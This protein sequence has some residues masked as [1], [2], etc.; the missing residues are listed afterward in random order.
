MGGNRFAALADGVPAAAAP[1]AR[2][3]A[4]DPLDRL[5]FLPVPRAPPASHRGSSR[6]VRQRH[7]AAWREST[8]VNGVIAGL[9][10]LSHGSGS[11]ARPSYSQ[12][13]VDDRR[14][15]ERLRVRVREYLGRQ[16]RHSAPQTARA[17][18]ARLVRDPGIG[19]SGLRRGDVVPLCVDKLALPEVRKR[20]RLASTE[21]AGRFVRGWR[22]L[23]L[24]P[25]DE[26]PSPEVITATR[27]YGDPSLRGGALVKL[28][29]RLLK[30]G[31]AVPGRKILPYGVRMFAVH[32]RD[33]EQRLV[34]DMRRGNLYFRRP[35]A[36]EMASLETLAALD[37]SSAA[38]GDGA[39]HAFAG[40]VPDYFYRLQLPDEM[41]GLFWV[42]GLEGCAFDELRAAALDA[43]YP[44]ALFDGGEALCL[45]VPCMGFSWAPLLAQLTL[46]EI[47]DGTSALAG[48][49]VVHH[50]AAPPGL[51]V[52]EP[53]RAQ[54]HWAYID[55]Y[56]GVCVEPTAEGARRKA[57]RAGAAVRGA[58][59]AKQ[60][61]A[62]KEQCDTALTVLGGEFELD[63][64]R[65]VPKHGSFGEL[66]LA[67]HYAASDG[68]RVSA[69]E[70]EM[71]LGK[72]AWFLLLRRGLFSCLDQAYHWVQDRRGQGH[73]DEVIKLW[74]A[75]DDPPYGWRPGFDAGLGRRALRAKFEVATLPLR[76]RRELRLL[77][78]L[79]PF[80]S[81]DLSWSWWGEVSMVDAG[82]EG[83][84]V[85][86]ADVGEAAARGV[87]SAYLGA[88]WKRFEDGVR[89]P[90]DIDA[91]L[92][93][94][95]TAWRVAFTCSQVCPEH[96]NVSE[97]RA[98]L[99]AVRRL[100]R[101][102]GCRGCRVV[103][104]T[105]SLVALGVASKG[106]SSSRPLLFQARRLAA[107]TL[108]AEITPV[109]PYVPS[110]WNLADAATR[111]GR[112]VGVH[113]ETASKAGDR[114][115]SHIA[116]IRGPWAVVWC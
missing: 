109:W 40:D 51:A 60:L 59:E 21:R 96:N 68:A 9:C 45:V 88:G 111:G 102:R 98:G 81:A 8:V 1:A 36:C 103:I 55:D 83:V 18:W 37:L 52:M 26:V 63:A 42:D 28:G 76:V 24:L 105:D 70:L 5:P 95:Q 91:A 78:R 94:P 104:A 114:G 74:H 62:H 112:R 34:F 49:Q 12:A 10:E 53:S 85:V 113:H 61:G 116:E 3:R 75:D 71:L 30:S 72:W 86:V 54:L 97:F 47:L 27:S 29:L 99:A 15:V 87:G 110:E 43:G 92:L 7:R 82:P 64:R 89:P 56:G 115:R 14:E 6:R 38:V 35:P 69:H 32:K 93:G 84:A 23:M 73:R 79:A 108:F 4:R 57:Q 33:D 67:T 90:P 77:C 66:V 31:M 58:L 13:S 11:S 41:V 101:N 48:S 2:S 16:D 106:R 20:L 22:E 46:E 65:I 107:L 100:V 50:K 39:L 25:A 80:V 17:A 44:S 19:Y